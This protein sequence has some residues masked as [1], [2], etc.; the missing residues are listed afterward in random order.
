M[1]TN[2]KDVWERDYAHLAPQKK[3]KKRD[4]FEEWLYRKKDEDTA[5]DEFRRYSMAGSATPVT[6]RFD[7]IAWW[8][9]P[10]VEEAFPTL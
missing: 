9:Q 6:E 1:L 8:S 10:D 4:A 5:T 2:Y 7:P 3:M